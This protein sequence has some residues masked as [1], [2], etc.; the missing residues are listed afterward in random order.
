MV[1]STT[2]CCTGHRCYCTWQMAWGV[3]IKMLSL[4]FDK[5]GIAHYGRTSTLVSSVTRT[6]M[7]SW[8]SFCSTEDCQLSWMTIFVESKNSF[9]DHC[10]HL[11]SLIFNAL[12]QQTAKTQAFYIVTLT[13]DELSDFTQTLLTLNSKM[14]LVFTHHFYSFA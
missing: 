10:R 3:Q 9:L 11:T 6:C 5:C 12:G 8:R 13:D 1:N 7:K 2:A 14:Y 4:V